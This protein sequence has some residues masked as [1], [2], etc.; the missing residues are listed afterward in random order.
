M[1][2]GERATAPFFALDADDDDPENRP[3]A[4]EGEPLSQAIIRER[5]RRWRRTGRTSSIQRLGQ[6]GP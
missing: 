4:I 2:L 6:L 1:A 3:I 5:R